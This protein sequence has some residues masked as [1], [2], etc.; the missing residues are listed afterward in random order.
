MIYVHWWQYELVMQK[1]E[2]KCWFGLQFFRTFGHSDQPLSFSGT[3]FHK[4][5]LYGSLSFFFPFMIESTM[6]CRAYMKFLSR[7]KYEF[8]LFECLSIYNWHLDCWQSKKGQ[9][10]CIFFCWC[11]LFCVKDNICNIWEFSIYLPKINRTSVHG[12]QTLAY[13]DLFYGCLMIWRVTLYWRKLKKSN[14]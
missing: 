1:F 10:S 6:V 14:S 12:I 8:F 3:Y 11:C 13:L 2:C 4:S 5:S 7:G 9:L